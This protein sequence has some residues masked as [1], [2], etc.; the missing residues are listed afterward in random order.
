MIMIDLLDENLTVK[1]CIIP[2][3]IEWKREERQDNG[4][5]SS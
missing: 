2:N 3:L 5:E 4:R 1:N